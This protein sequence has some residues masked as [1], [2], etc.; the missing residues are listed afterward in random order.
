LVAGQL[1]PQRTQNATEWLGAS[2]LLC[3]RPIDDT[4]RSRLEDQSKHFDG[5]G[6]QSSC[7]QLAPLGGVGI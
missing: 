3:L 5:G 1:S 7:V 6:D 2:P 4:H